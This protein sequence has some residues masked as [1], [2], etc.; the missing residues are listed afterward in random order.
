[1]VGRLQRMSDA[2]RQMHIGRGDED[3]A[4]PDPDLDYSLQRSGVPCLRLLVPDQRDKH[5]AI[6]VHKRSP[7]RDVASREVIL[8]TL[9][10]RT[11]VLLGISSLVSPGPS[12]T[13]ENGA[14]SRTE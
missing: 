12:S 6:R 3:I 8:N 7:E 14:A 13:L 10:G 1:M 9:A 5:V 4:A 11:S 2:L